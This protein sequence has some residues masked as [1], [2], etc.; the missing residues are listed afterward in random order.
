[1]KRRIKNKIH[2]QFNRQYALDYGQF[3]SDKKTRSAIIRDL[4]RQLNEA[5]NYYYSL[6]SS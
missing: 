1:M 6:Y 4:Y 5:A 2:N 3:T